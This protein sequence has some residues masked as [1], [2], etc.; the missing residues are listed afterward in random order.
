MINLSNKTAV[1]TGSTRGFGLAIAEAILQAGGNV[2]ISSRSQSA[3]D[4]TL[5]RLNAGNHAAGLACDVSDLEQVRALS[6]AAIEKFG[7]FEIW[8]NNAG[9]SGPYGPTSGVSPQAFHTVINTNIT[10]AY[11]GT[12][13]ALEHF[14]ARKT[15]KLINILGHGY[16]SPVPFQSAYAA[17]KAWLRSFTMAVAKENQDSGV[18]VF[19]FNPGM[20]VTELL[21]D[22][23]VV[24]GSE[25]KLKVFP[26]II[27]MWGRPPEVAAQKAAW[28]ASSVTDGKTGK[29]YNLHSFGHTLSGAIK[30]GWRRLTKKPGYPMEVDMHTIPY[31]K[32]E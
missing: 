6:A 2:M 20:M 18:G 1:I 14:L 25:E 29:L 31:Y 32:P 27:R 13:V 22:V 10:G 23:D 8:I 30:E 21:T 19:A 11:H 12:K 5:D 24:A 4:Q 17:S 9:T 15:G 28:I 7:S 16:K 3:V 26:T